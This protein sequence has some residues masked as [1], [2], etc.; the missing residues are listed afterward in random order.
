MLFGWVLVSYRVLE[1]MPHFLG[2]DY[3]HDPLWLSAK[4][5]GVLVK[6]GNGIG[7]MT[8]ANCLA[9]ASC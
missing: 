8:P 9:T 5:L 1:G 7:H 4:A 6:M 3:N 2:V